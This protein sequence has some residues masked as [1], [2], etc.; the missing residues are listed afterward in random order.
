MRDLHAGQGHT[1]VAVC[2]TS[3]THAATHLI[4]M[5]EGTIVAE[6]DP[7]IVV[8]ADLVEKVFGLP[9][10]VIADPETHTPMIVPVDRRGARPRH[11]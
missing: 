3:T 8:T 10:R 5:Q 7:A 1:L 9:V 6:G 4:V 11:D 2:T